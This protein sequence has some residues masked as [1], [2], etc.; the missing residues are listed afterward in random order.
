MGETDGESKGIIR[1]IVEIFAI[2][3]GLAAAID[4]LAEQ[5][6][7]QFEQEQKAW[8]VLAT[9]QAKDG[10]GNIGQLHAFDFLNKNGVPM[11]GIQI[12]GKEFGE[13]PA[14]QA[15]L[16]GAR[17]L[18]SNLTN[19]H[20]KCATLNYAVFENSAISG[21]DFTHADLSHAVFSKSDVSGVQFEG[22]RAD[23][24]SFYDAYYRASN[25]PTGSKEILPLLNKCD[26]QI[27]D[28]NQDKCIKE[29]KNLTVDDRPIYA[30]V[31][32]EKQG[33]KFVDADLWSRTAIDTMGSDETVKA[34]YFKARIDKR[35][36]EERN[37]RLRINGG[38]TVNHSVTLK[39]GGPADHECE[40]LQ[41]RS[42][43]K[44]VHLWH[45]ITSPF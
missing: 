9:L 20:F 11:S 19:A 27:Y 45:S 41:L 21:A 43:S 10:R 33:N 8:S 29:N 6:I 3:G 13:L 40:V 15:S 4:Y 26:D 7:R 17:L 37:E 2:I 5:D 18:N 38:T 12:D 34:T 35:I 31:L 23:Q 30:A 16:S 39:A 14:E 22:A 42:R 36:T 1:N 25:A 24:L 32:A 28:E 44:L